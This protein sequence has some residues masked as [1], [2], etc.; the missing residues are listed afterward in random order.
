MNVS[1][2][3]KKGG[4]I[5]P[6]KDKHYLT[7]Q[8]TD[9]DKNYSF[10]AILLYIMG[11]LSIILGIYEGLRLL[12]EAHAIAKNA[13]FIRYIAMAFLGGGIVTGVLFIG[14]GKNISLLQEIS[15]K[16]DNM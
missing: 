9:E 3:V 4:E 16:L 12:R 10:I 6:E 15:E 2:S 14:F 7:D 13:H 1:Y 8:K 5:M 11:I